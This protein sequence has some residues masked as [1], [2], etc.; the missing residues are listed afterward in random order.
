[1]IRMNCYCL[2][3]WSPLHA[4]H[5]KEMDLLATATLSFVSCCWLSLSPRPPF[6]FGWRESSG[7]S[8]SGF[9]FSIFLCVLLWMIPKSILSMHKTSWRWSLVVQIHLLALLFRPGTAIFVTLLSVSFLCGVCK[10][11]SLAVLDLIGLG[12][13]VTSTFIWKASRCVVVRV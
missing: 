5:V 13:E 2:A 4:W 1:M 9:F 10:Q 8:S 11:W 6:F 12:V 7:S 3:C